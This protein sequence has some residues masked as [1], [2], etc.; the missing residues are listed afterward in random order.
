VRRDGHGRHFNKTARA[1]SGWYRGGMQTGVVVAVSRDGMHAFSKPQLPSITLVEGLGVEGDAHFG[2]TVQ[3]QSRVA[4]DPTQLNLRQ[5]HLIHAELHDQLRE[6]GFDVSAGQLGENI[7]TRGVDLLGLPTR[8]RLGVGE[9]VV[10]E[11]TGLRNPCLQIDNFQQGL[12]K[13]MVDRDAAGTV[14]RKAGIMGVVVVGGA[15]RPG[16]TIETRLP[17]RPWLA[18]ECV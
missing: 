11:I 18:L 14:V 13:H 9:S 12:L 7:T 3:H 15:V 17:E 10:I 6:M 1:I 8:T 5:V 4:R 16:D 2:A